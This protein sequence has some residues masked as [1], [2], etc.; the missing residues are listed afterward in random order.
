M[1]VPRDQLFELKAL[2]AEIKL[3]ELQA[4][5]AIQERMRR[6]DEILGLWESEF[7]GKVTSVDFEKETVEVGTADTGDTEG[8]G[9]SGLDGGGGAL[10]PEVHARAHPDSQ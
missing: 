4:S 5:Q 2:M 9:A 7:G 3:I 8:L 6:R 10:V 1:Q